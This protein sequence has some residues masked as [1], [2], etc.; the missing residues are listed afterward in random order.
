MSAPGWP[1]R[2]PPAQPLPPESGRRWKRDPWHKPRFLAGFTWAYLA[3]SIVPVALAVL[4]SF[5]TGSSRSVWQ[6]FSLRWYYQDPVS[7]SCTIRSCTAL[8]Q[9]LRL[10]VYVTLVAVP[11]GVAFALGID[12]WRGRPASIW[13]FQMI[14]SFVMPELIFGVAM[15]FVFTQL[16]TWWPGDAGPGP[17]PSSTSARR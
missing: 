17:R 14:L 10:A 15:F 13:N 11:L 9:T 8:F 4:F 3:W 12:R 1:D 7:R 6:G 5:N 2:L 16:F